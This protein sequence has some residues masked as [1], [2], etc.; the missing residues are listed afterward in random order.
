MIT[1]LFLNEMAKALAGESYVVPT[2]LAFGSSVITESAGSTTLSGEFGSRV[3]VTDS[4]ST[5]TVTFTGTRSA[6]SVSTSAGDTLNSMGL[7][8]SSS[9]GTHLSET[10]LSSII[11]TTTFDIEVESIITFGRA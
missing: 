6:A 5:S 11:H 4:R 1:D 7:K 8:S 3:A 10:A 2:Y 9:G